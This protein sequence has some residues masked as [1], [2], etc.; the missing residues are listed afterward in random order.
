MLDFDRALEVCIE[1]NLQ[2]GA[3]FHEK[4]AHFGINEE[5]QARYVKTSVVY[6]LRNH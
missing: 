5:D 3:N 2:N 1:L 6:W 4:K